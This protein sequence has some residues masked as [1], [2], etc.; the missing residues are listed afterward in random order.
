MKAPLVGSWAQPQPKSNWCILVLKYDIW[1]QQFN[2]FPEIV[3]TRQITTKTEK[4]FLFLVRAF[5]AL[6]LLVGRQKGHPAYKKL[7]G[8]V[9]A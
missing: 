6:T 2:D 7:S 1:W 3:P 5:S 8:G 4:A 9:L